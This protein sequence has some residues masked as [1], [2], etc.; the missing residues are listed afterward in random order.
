MLPMVVTNIQ[1]AIRDEIGQKPSVFLH[2]DVKNKTGLERMVRKV[3]LDSAAAPGQCSS[4]RG[5]QSSPG[6]PPRRR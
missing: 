3:R 2:S 5:C 6:V 1:D 4:Q